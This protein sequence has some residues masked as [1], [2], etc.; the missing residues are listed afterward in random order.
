MRKRRRK[1]ERKSERERE[2]ERE[3]ERERERE[4]RRKRKWKRDRETQ[5]HL[6]RGTVRRVVL[7]VS[8]SGPLALSPIR[9]TNVP[10]P[11]SPGPSNRLRQ[12]I[13]NGSSYGGL[14]AGKREKRGKGREK[15]KEETR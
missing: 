3:Q 2:R 1:S 10:T 6:E 11:A 5:T 13:S 15:R 9:K 8:L 14:P 4:E 7:S 12:S